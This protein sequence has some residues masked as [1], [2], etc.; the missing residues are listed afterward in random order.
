MLNK[1]ILRA[2]LSIS[3]ALSFAGAAN[4]TLI[5][6]D[7]LSGTDV[8]GHISINLDTA[9]DAGN[10]FSSVFVWEDFSLLGIDMSA[11]LI[12]D[13]FQFLA[14]YNT[15]NLFDGIQNLTTDVDDVLGAFAWQFNVFD[16]LGTLDVFNNNT[17]NIALF[18]EN[19]SFG[20]ASV[21]PEP[22]ALILLFTG[23]VAFATRRKVSK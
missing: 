2:F 5:S 20:S 21:V 18:D 8:I 14:E 7:I 16:G 6:Q 12:A 13:G 22:S 11:P 23:L 15:A 1:L 4:A 9:E 10:G 3:L 17:G 19:I